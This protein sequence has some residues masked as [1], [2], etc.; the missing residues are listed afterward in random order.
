[1]TEK[2]I[3]LVW[4]PVEKADK[5]TIP[6]EVLEGGR[7]TYKLPSTLAFGHLEFNGVDITGY[8]SPAD[9]DAEY[10]VRPWMI[11]SAPKPVEDD[12]AE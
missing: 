9:D 10:V 12:E 4:V 5:E 7:L 8:F 1:M 2:K 6:F 3:K 11:P